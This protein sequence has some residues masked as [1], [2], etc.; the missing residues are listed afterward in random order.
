MSLRDRQRLDDREGLNGMVG[1]FRTGTAWRDVPERYGPWATLHT[2]FRRRTLGT[3]ERMLRAAQAHADA[4]GDIDWPV[5]AD[6]TKFSSAGAGARPA[7]A[8]TRRG[9]R[10]CLRRRNLLS[11][12]RRGRPRARSVGHSPSDQAPIS[13]SS[14]LGLPI[15]AIHS[16]GA[17]AAL[18]RPASA[19]RTPETPACEEPADRP[20][21]TA[22]CYGCRPLLMPK[23]ARRRGCAVRVGGVGSPGSPVARVV[24]DDVGR[25]VVEHPEMVGDGARGRAAWT[26]TRA[27][28]MRCSGVV[29]A[30]TR[31]W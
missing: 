8:D 14:A 4:A 18:C 23:T 1:K 9:R 30:A 27:R 16:T 15:A 3:F 7:A 22:G 11:R 2:R 26:A 17:A 19:R 29:A 5:S 28:V 13:P 21:K 31:G 24:A 10:P 12:G 20:R 25:E 6:S